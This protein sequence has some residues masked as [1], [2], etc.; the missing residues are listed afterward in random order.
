MT[1]ITFQKFPIFAKTKKM[2]SKTS[3]LF[4]PKKNNRTTGRCCGFQGR[5]MW[6][7][8]CQALVGPRWEPWRAALR[9]GLLKQ[10]QKTNRKTT[11]VFTKRK[12]E[13]NRKNNWLFLQKE[14]NQQK[15]DVFFFFFTNWKKESDEPVW[16]L[17]ARWFIC[18]FCKRL[19]TYCWKWQCLKVRKVGHCSLAHFGPRVCHGICLAFWQI[20]VDEDGGR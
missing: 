20:W 1:S 3:S 2:N 5:S 7:L 6:A 19:L 8:R 9:S 15:K 13:T 14:R 10:K 4:F 11:G 16:S 18:F 12:K 17:I